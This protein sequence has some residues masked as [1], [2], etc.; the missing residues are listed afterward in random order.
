MAYVHPLNMLHHKICK[1]HSA[2]VV[3]MVIKALTYKWMDTVESEQRV[4]HLPLVDF[5]SL[6]FCSINCFIWRCS[7]WVSSCWKEAGAFLAWQRVKTTAPLFPGC[8]IGILLPDYSNICVD[9][10]AMKKLVSEM[11][12]VVQQALVVLQALVGWGEQQTEEG[13]CCLLLLLLY[14]TDLIA[15]DWNK[16]HF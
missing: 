4:H 15:A 8:C 2:K 13:F 7:S 16:A 6:P 3:H 10:G 9:G 5:F 11:R 12:V 1:D 14:I